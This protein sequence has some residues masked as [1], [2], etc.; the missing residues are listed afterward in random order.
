MSQRAG[1]T[2]RAALSDG[3]AEMNLRNFFRDCQHLLEEEAKSGYENMSQQESVIHSKSYGTAA[4]FFEQLVEHINDGGS[5]P[6]EKRE[7]AR[8]LGI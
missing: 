8:I 5:L 6:K 4:F 1:K 7:I 3:M 2:H